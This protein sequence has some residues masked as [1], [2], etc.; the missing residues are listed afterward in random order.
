MGRKR[1]LLAGATLAFVFLVGLQ[2]SSREKREDGVA[3]TVT[4][5][6]QARDTGEAVSSSNQDER[7]GPQTRAPRAA[8]TIEGDSTFIDNALAEVTT[9][10][11]SGQLEEALNELDALYA[12]YEILNN[13]E[14]FLVMSG[15]ANYFLAAGELEEV[16]RI[17][18]ESLNIADLPGETLLLIYRTLGQLGLRLQQYDKGIAYFDSYLE[19][20][21]QLNSQITNSLANAYFALGNFASANQTLRSSI[22][23]LHAEGADSASPRIANRYESLFDLPLRLESDQERISLG[24]LLVDEFDAV[25]TYQNLAE[26]YRVAGDEIRADALLEE[27]RANGILEDS[28]N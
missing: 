3:E 26:I 5:E 12:D 25:L 8:T 22:E 19:I 28:A 11:Q 7:S 18:E 1:W 14:Q 21:G 23:L 17:Y 20:G 24:Q 6:E 16:M 15:Y 2:F 10:L 27:A 13:E 9:R 4:P